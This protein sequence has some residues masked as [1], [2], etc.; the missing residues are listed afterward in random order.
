[1][2]VIYILNVFPKIS[3]AFI[4]NEILEI[5]RK[6]IAV[7]VFAF[8]KANEDKVHSS[9]QKIRHVYYF[10][11]RNFC[12]LIYAHFYWFFQKP[13]SYAKALVFA[14]KRSNG[15]TRLFLQNLYEVILISKSKPD[16]I[17]VHFGTEASNLALLT[18]L[19]TG[20]DFT[21]T[22][23]AYDIFELPPRNYQIKSK[24]AKMHITVS[25]YN[26]K[27]IVEKFNVDK[28]KI[29]VIYSGIDFKQIF[30]TLKH[31]GENILLSVARLS[32]EKGL[33]NLI[34]ACYKLKKQGIIFKC[35]I[36]GEGDE[37]K[38]LEELIEKFNLD[39]EVKLLGNKIQDEVFELLAMA[40]IKILPSRSES[41]S[42]SLMEA[43]ALRV[44]VI[45]PRI[46]GM[47]EL[48][49]DGKCGFLVP[50]DKVDILV[51]K[52]KILL[53]DGNLRKYFAENGY[54]KVLNDFNLQTET[55]KL[56]EIWKKN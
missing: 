24:L 20:I 41:M 55:D 40:T 5:Q 35:L 36:V 4:L 43:M 39:N 37:R 13:H 14:L 44:P 31:R 45:G 54:K 52:I 29:A 26:K 32:K 48:I 22:T 46:Y 17:H 34:Q 21:F 42:V 12:R 47:P 18:H 10:P 1:M 9:V 30:P 50:P 28:K 8:S 23:H 7:E 25:E 3:E 51:E 19:I 15:V 49:E 53:N 38:V 27:F 33:D 2:R 11:R 6:G 16:H 56:V